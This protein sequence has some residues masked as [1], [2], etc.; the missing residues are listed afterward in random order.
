VPGLRLLS[1]NLHELRGDVRVIHRVLTSARADLVCLQEVPRGVRSVPR[2]A[3]LAAQVGLLAV[4]GGRASAGTAVLCSVRI[5]VLASCARLLPV[6]GRFT[7]PR[8]VVTVTA[9]VI[10]AAP[11]AL[12]CVHLPL[13]P[14]LRVRH[15]VAVRDLLAA[16]GLPS[17]L[18][19]DLNEPPGG[20]TW[21]GFGPLLQDPWP[22]GGPTCPA[23]RPAHRIDAVLVGR[24][25]RAAPVDDWQPDADDL[26]AASDHLPV[27][28]ALHLPVLAPPGRG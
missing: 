14:G 13:D 12:A 17:V 1:W 6:P 8:G 27:L 4:A 7:R 26:R 2:L 16:T 18:A 15:A 5:Q 23:R 22:G 21:Q 10:G 28:A 20:A 3:G 19:G 25:V 11:L 24:G 9:R